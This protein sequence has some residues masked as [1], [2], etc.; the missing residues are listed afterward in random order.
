MVISFV[1]FLFSFVCGFISWGAIGYL[2]IMN[3]PNQTQVTSVG[4]TFIAL[5]EVATYGSSGWYTL[6]L[7]FL[8]AT[9]I[10]QTCAFIE[11]FVT[12][13]IDAWK[14][15]RW[16]AVLGV[17]TLGAAIS[18]IFSTN[19]GWQLFDMTE[20]FMNRYVIL[21]VGLLQCIAVGW[22]FEYD[23]TANCSADHKRSLRAL[24]VLYWVPNIVIAFYC[25]FSFS[26]VKYWGLLVVLVCTLGALFSSFKISKMSYDSWLHEVV[27]CGVDKVA[28]G[29]TSLT[30]CDHQRAAWMISFESY[31]GISIKFINPSLLIWILM[32]NLME[33]LS[34]PYNDQIYTMYIYSTIP[35]FVAVLIVAISF[36][37]CTQPEVFEHNINLEFLADN[38]YEMKLRMA[39]YFKDQ[40][41]ERMSLGLM[42][43]L[44]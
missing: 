4:L 39:K 20:H 42:G 8:F 11:G 5:P 6:F 23:T 40:M 29:V 41:Q 28:M 1:S 2:N 43:K 12:N 36:F 9:G 35:A 32:S 16:K 30:K 34:E 7:V 31:F 14:V 26:P 33:D 24:S 15:K 25:N 3:N 37:S 22:V 13:I 17:C 18:A 44:Q 38:L 27:L 21:S 19:L 10:T